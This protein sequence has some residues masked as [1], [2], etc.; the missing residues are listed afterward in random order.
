MEELKKLLEQ[1]KGESIDPFGLTKRGLNFEEEKQL[2]PYDSF[3]LE[4]SLR[5]IYNRNNLEEV[6]DRISS[7][8]DE[9]SGLY[10]I[11]VGDVNSEYYN[12]ATMFNRMSNQIYSQRVWRSVNLL[13]GIIRNIKKDYMDN[14]NKVASPPGIPEEDGRYR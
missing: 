3:Y 11:T 7:R 8:F 10:N 12:F 4:D 1:R 2:T 5:L 9:K 14:I 13:E 6:K